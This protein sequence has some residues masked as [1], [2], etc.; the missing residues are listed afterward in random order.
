M[1]ILVGH[2]QLSKKDFVDVTIPGILVKE[3]YHLSSLAPFRAHRGNELLDA[4]VE[5][6]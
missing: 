6:E 2:G 4:R 3:L 5:I 1:M